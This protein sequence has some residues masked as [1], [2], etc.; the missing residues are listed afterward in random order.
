MLRER[1][2]QPPEVIWA[3]VLEGS[4]C[5]GDARTRARRS[6]ATSVQFKR[7]EPQYHAMVQTADMGQQLAVLWCPALECRTTHRC[8]GGATPK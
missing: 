8:W 4:P 7:V 5:C 6:T 2:V 3:V 1:V